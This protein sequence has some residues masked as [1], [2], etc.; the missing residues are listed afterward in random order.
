MVGGSLRK[1][2][3]SAR[4]WLFSYR[5]PNLK[6]VTGTLFI[7]NS[8]LIPA[9]IGLGWEATQALDNFEVRCSPYYFSDPS[10]EN[11][12]LAFQFNSFDAPILFWNPTIL[13]L[14]LYWSL[15]LNFNLSTVDNGFFS[16]D[17]GPGSHWVMMHFVFQERFRGEHYSLASISFLESESVSSLFAQDRYR[18]AT[19]TY[20]DPTSVGTQISLGNFTANRLDNLLLYAFSQNHNISHWNGRVCSTVPG[21]P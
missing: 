16:T 18:L 6:Y 1:A 3:R 14:H 15:Q 2:L 21:F 5:H 11:T 8:L 7:I 10:Y 12:T 20:S 19:Y 17:I 4:M 13:T 9:F